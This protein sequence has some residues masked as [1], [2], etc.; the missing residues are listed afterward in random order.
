MRESSRCRALFPGGNVMPEYRVY[1]LDRNDRVISRK[2]IVA[3]SDEAAM[4]A[5]SQYADGG[6]VEVWERARKVGRVG[7]Y[8]KK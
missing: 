4:E 7:G 2:D 5:A 6:D 1:L 8:G 3:P